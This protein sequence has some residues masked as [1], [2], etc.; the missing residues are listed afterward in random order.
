[1]ILSALLLASAAHVEAQGTF[2]NLN[3][4]AATV[5]YLTNTGSLVPTSAAFPG[6]TVY[7]GNIPQSTVAYNGILPAGGILL[8]TRDFAA[9]FPIPPSFGSFSM[10]PKPSSSFDVS[11]S[12]VGTLPAGAHELLFESHGDFPLV[13]ANFQFRFGS[14]L[15]PVELV[16]QAGLVSSWRASLAGLGGQT[17]E[18][19]IGF[20]GP[21]FVG[22]HRFDNLQFT[23]IPE[24]GTWALLGLGGA[25]L[26]CGARR[27]RK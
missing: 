22:F 21:D 25:C 8:W 20:S 19:S 3:F 6:W 17:D 27:R 24:P 23:S 9:V 7:Y 12:Q 4:E 15:L 5:P 1:M 14:T 18:L 2:V 26:W 16:S 11:L 13:P 10:I